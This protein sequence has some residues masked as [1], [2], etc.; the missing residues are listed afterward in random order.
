MFIQW[1]SIRWA[2][3]RNVLQLIFEVIHFFANAL[4]AFRCPPVSVWTEVTPTY[5][6]QFYD[7]LVFLKLLVDSAYRSN[8]GPSFLKTYSSTTC[9]MTVTHNECA[10]DCTTLGRNVVNPKRNSKPKP[11]TKAWKLLKKVKKTQ[12]HEKCN[13]Y[14]QNERHQ[15]WE[16]NWKPFVQ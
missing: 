12:S 14:Y 2:V 11:L 7:R 9:N 5:K 4:F 13:H 16:L 1:W 8:N 15:W 6:N 10:I 3:V